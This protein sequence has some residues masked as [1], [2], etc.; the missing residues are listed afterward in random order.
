MRRRRRRRRGRVGRSSGAGRVESRRLSSPRRREALRQASHSRSPVRQNRASCA[1][2]AAA[3]RRAESGLCRMTARSVHCPV[4]M[5]SRVLGAGHS[6]KGAGIR[7]ATPQCDNAA[8]IIRCLPRI[9]TRARERAR[10]EA[11]RGATR[12]RS[13]RPLPPPQCCCC[14]CPRIM[15]TC[16]AEL[17]QRGQ[18]PRR[19]PL[20]G[21]RPQQTAGGRHQAR[22][23]GC[24]TV[25]R[26]LRDSNAIIWGEGSRE[27]RGDECARRESDLRRGCCRP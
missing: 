3:E 5:P 18:A 14:R 4:L 12:P 9:H 15:M 27:R 17:L 13:P 25:G 26:G 6:Q 24:Q 23:A 21:L 16:L 10:H 19:V 8:G 1:G 2:R 20:Q 11:A 7:L 22:R